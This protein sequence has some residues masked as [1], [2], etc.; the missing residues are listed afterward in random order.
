MP[1]DDAHLTALAKLFAALHRAGILHNDLNSSNIRYL[2]THEGTEFSLIDLNRMHTYAKQPSQR[3]CIANTFRFTFS[4]ELYARFIPLYLK[5]M[6][7][8]TPGMAEKAIA[9]KL[10]FE[11]RLNRKRRLTHPIKNFFRKITGA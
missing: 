3:E 11:E 4:K 1:A 10:Y 8:L 2:D 9:K 5:E 7:W 6:R